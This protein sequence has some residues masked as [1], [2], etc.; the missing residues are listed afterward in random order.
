MPSLL[1]Y[2]N[3]SALTV[4]SQIARPS[5]LHFQERKGGLKCVTKYLSVCKK[6]VESSL[7]LYHSSFQT[8]RILV[9][10]SGMTH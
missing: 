2:L 1:W 7:P 8:M 10:G 5:L 6:D 3:I 4:K 9:R